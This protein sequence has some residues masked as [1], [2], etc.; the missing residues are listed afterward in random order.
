[1]NCMRLETALNFPIRNTQGNSI[2]YEDS[3]Y[4]GVSSLFFSRDPLAIVWAVTLFIVSAIKGMEFRRAKPHIRNKVG[5]II[6]SFADF[7]SPASIIMEVGTS[8]AIAS[9]A[10]GHPNAIF[11][12]SFSRTFGYNDFS[13]VR[14]SPYVVRADQRA[15]AVIGSFY[16]TYNISPLKGFSMKGVT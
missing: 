6:P 16:Y 2:V 7:Y 15:T 9:I 1:M 4:A 11:G 12:D 14:G 13:H 3:V 8:L 5:K 10:H